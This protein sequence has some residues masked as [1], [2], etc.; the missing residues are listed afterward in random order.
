MTQKRY[1]KKSYDK[2]GFILTKA[3]QKSYVVKVC[4]AGEESLSRSQRWKH[5]ADYSML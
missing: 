1:K 2:K 4:L 5:G 3:P